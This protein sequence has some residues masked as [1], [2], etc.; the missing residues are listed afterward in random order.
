[1]K[2]PA[3]SLFVTTEPALMRE[4]H[5]SPVFQK[6]ALTM[7][8]DVHDALKRVRGGLNPDIAFVDLADPAGLEMLGELRRSNPKMVVVAIS[9]NHNARQAVDAMRIGVQ[10]CIVKPC[11]RRDFEDI[12]TRCLGPAQA[13]KNITEMSA[14]S[15]HCVPIAASPAMRNIVA[16]CQRAA[17]VDSPI[18]IV[19]ESGTG[20]EVMARFIHHL[21]SRAKNPFLKVNCAA[22]PDE[23]LESE[24]FG[25]E[26][27]AFTGAT[28]TKPGKFEQAN[29]GT[30]LL[31]EVGELPTNLQAKL[32]H[33]LQDGQFSR[34]GGRTTIQVNVRVLAATN[35]DIEEALA[36][37][38]LR[39]DLY[40]RLNTFLVQM[41]ALRDRKEEI[42]LLLNHFICEYARK[43]NIEILEPSQTL[44]AACNNHLWPG[45]VRELENFAKRL[46]ILRDESTLLQE[47]LT[48]RKCAVSERN[49]RP[50]NGHSIADH[51][52]KEGIP[53]LKSVA[54]SAMAEA[55]SAAI[56]EALLHTKWNRRRAAR[57]LDISYKALLYKIKDYDL[58]GR[59]TAS[60]A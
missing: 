9:E 24:L 15:D 8:S 18:L 26:V 11:T 45:N 3:K 23:L 12:V 36:N 30:I 39:E 16:Y 25:Y 1:M 17:Q 14:A 35:V 52:G 43:W 10:D 4:V 37:R 40:Y 53:N 21:S 57:L 44:I 22:V 5:N 42:C 47:L 34:L 28:H 51:N 54:R 2:F 59:V 27:G 46:L 19:G 48:T 55:E 33:V 41:P 50:A 49:R 13:H 7:V 38:R 6:H 29:C 20:K 60:D 58:A 56:Y 31:D 32:L